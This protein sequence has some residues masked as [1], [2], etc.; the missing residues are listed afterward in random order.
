M[1]KR[2]EKMQIMKN[3]FSSNYLKQGPVGQRCVHEAHEAHIAHLA[4]LAHLAH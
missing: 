2:S 3:L 4:H 1:Q